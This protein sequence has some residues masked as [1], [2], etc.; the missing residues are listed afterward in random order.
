[1]FVLYLKFK[2]ASAA[3]QRTSQQVQNLAQ[4]VN[5][6]AQSSITPAKAV[7]PPTQSHGALAVPAVF[8]SSGPRNVPTQPNPNLK[9][10]NIKINMTL[11]GK[12]R[13][14]T[15]H[16]GTLVAIKQ[17]GK[18]M[19]FIACIILFWYCTVH[20]ILLCVYVKNNIFIKNLDSFFDIKISQGT[21]S[22]TR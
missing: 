17:V 21:I 5:R 19:Q 3:L 18:C 22:S 20:F 6:T 16:R 14:K 8:M 10:D 1:M 12:K 11:L 4:S 15:W 2:E 7:A 13:T 9:Q